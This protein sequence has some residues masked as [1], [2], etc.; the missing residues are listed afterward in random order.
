MQVHCLMSRK[1]IAMD[2]FRPLNCILLEFCDLFSSQTLTRGPQ[3][4]VSAADGPNLRTRY[5]I[6]RQDIDVLSE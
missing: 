6:T 3:V 2:S 5:H 4:Y 1:K